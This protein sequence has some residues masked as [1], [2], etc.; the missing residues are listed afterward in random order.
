MVILTVTT[1]VINKCVY[2]IMK[3][4]NAV[5]LVIDGRCN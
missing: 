1:I 3:F 5:S 2:S 4:I